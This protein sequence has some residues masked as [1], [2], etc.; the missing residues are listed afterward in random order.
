MLFIIIKLV[1]SIFAQ[2]CKIKFKE[3][4]INEKYS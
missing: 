4:K 1:V 2:Q 3:G